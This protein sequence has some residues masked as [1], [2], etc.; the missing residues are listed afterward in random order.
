MGFLLTR[1]LAVLT[2]WGVGEAGL[3]H[4]G[5]VTPVGT[6]S[7][8]CPAIQAR[9]V[10]GRAWGSG[11]PALAFLP[12]EAQP[13]VHACSCLLAHW[14]VGFQGAFS[15]WLPGHQASKLSRSTRS[16]QNC[17]PADFDARWAMDSSAGQLRV[18]CP[19]ATAI[20][21]YPT[22]QFHCNFSLWHFGRPACRGY[23]S[24]PPSRR[25]VPS[26]GKSPA[27]TASPGCARSNLLAIR[28][29]KARE[30][31]HA[32]CSPH[33]EWLHRHSAI[34]MGAKEGR[35]VGGEGGAQTCLLLCGLCWLARMLRRGCASRIACR[36]A[37]EP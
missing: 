6:F 1:R 29:S 32:A 4:S 33:L 23:R 19:G 36:A 10:Y 16:K 30:C 15:S 21:H 5:R 12:G 20:M 11:G 34:I 18:S 14:A 3:P 7:C 25:C 24:P 17:A 31:C 8:I 26:S 22:T 2:A 35:E 28:R 9:V 13:R 27:C 37:S